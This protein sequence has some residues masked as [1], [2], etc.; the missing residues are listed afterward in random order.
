MT[1]IQAIANHILQALTKQKVRMHEMLKTLES[2]LEAVKQRDGKK[3]SEIIAYKEQQL[4]DIQ[5]A[6]KEFNNEQIIEFINN[7]PELTELKDEI[8]ELLEQCQHQN[9]VVY[10]V[11]TQNQIAIDEVKRLLIGGSKNTTYD[12]LGQKHS[13]TLMGKGIKA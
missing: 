9:E 2:E 12:A 7:T 3:I 4:I 5:A 10:L 11:A 1:D 8:N 13:G 6:D